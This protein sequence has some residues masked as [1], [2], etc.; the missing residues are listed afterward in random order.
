MNPIK[1]EIKKILVI[2]L[3]FIGDVLLTTPVCR[4]LRAT[5]PNATIDML[6]IPLTEQVAVGNPYVNRVI[7]YDKRG[8]HKHFGALCAL[9]GR[10]R[11]E[12]YD[13]S[14]AMNFA[15]RGALLAWASGVKRRVGYDRQHAPWFLTDIADSSREQIRH[16]TENHLAILKPLQISSN[17]TSLV[18]KVKASD[19]ESLSHKV[20]FTERPALAVCP[21]GSYPKKSWNTD[22]YGQL[23]QKLTDTY[24]CFLLGSNGERAGLEEIAAKSGKSVPVLGGNLTLGELAAL[25]QQVKLLITVDTGPMHL[26]NAVGTPVVALFGPTD[27]RIWGPR[28]K[29]DQVIQAKSKCSPCWGKGECPGRHCMEKIEL[30]DVEKAV[31]AIESYSV[32]KDD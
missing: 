15:V 9:I 2:N 19:R 3:A 6:V 23:I 11:R 32:K 24:Q 14:L 8:R 30:S 10:L 17:D 5:Y 22:R 20:F 26:A 28:G 25:L 29:Y 1:H 16:E 4:G 31:R 18:F 12:H 7:V 13:L 27:P 21:F